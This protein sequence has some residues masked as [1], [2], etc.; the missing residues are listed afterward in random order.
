MKTFS[1]AHEAWDDEVSDLR[2]FNSENMSLGSGGAV[3][4]GFSVLR[5]VIRTLASCG[6]CGQ[7]CVFGYMTMLCV[8]P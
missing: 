1:L 3:A 2:S 6:G 7:A 8:L 4:P 5:L